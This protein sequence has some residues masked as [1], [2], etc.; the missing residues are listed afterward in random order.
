[1]T[2]TAELTYTDLPALMRRLAGD[3]KHNAAAESTVDVIWVLY[4]SVLDIGPHNLD[5]PGRDRFLLSKGHGPMAFYAVLAAKGL[6][7]AGDLDG[8]GTFESRLGGHPDRTLVPGAEISSGS[9]GHGLPIGLGLVLGWRATGRTGP[10]A[11]VL[12]GDAELDE[13]SNNEAIEYA[14]RLG[15]EQLTVV[16]VD[17]SSSTYGWPGGIER[18]FTLE[19]WTGR[20]VDGRDHDALRVAFTEPHP[21]RPLVVVAS[22]EKKGA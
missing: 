3:E 8:W 17:N 18:R 6:L 13:G 7:P 10:R 9:L 14:G 5:D 19:G 4:D 11:V 16:V 2:T 12:V 22:V 20:T 1:M 21:G 15:L